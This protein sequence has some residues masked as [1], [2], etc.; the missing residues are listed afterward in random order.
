MKKVALL[1]LAM[2]LGFSFAG[3]QEC[4]MY[5]PDEVG[6]I[7]E[8]RSYDQRNRLTSIV[9]H[10][11]LDKVVAD[12]SIRVKVRA[13]SYDRKESEV[14]SGDLEFICEDGVF[15]FDLRDYLDPSMIASYEEMGVD[16]TGTNLVYPAIMNVGANLPDGSVQMVVKSGGATLLTVSVN[17]SNRKIEAREQITTDAGT[18]M[19][20]KI[21]Y[22]VASRAGFINSN[23]SAIEW[24]AAGA[25]PVRTE[26]FDRRG[27][28]TGYSVLT[29]L[30]K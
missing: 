2:L 19:C 20:Y 24:I 23:S 13:T 9:R 6:T 12:N 5:F 26:T 4:P 29:S 14:H 8:I 25:G 22:D 17:I 7:R 16:I 21:T 1:F 11:I 10:E 28:L 18:F 30:K 3:A 27:R 15:T